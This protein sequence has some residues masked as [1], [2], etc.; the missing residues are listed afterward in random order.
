MDEAGRGTRSLV[1]HIVRG[2]VDDPSAVEVTQAEDERGAVIRVRVGAADI[3][4]VIGRGGR[5]AKAIRTLA[6][7]AAA[8]G[9]G[10]VFIE[11]AE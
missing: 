4:K 2:I 3:G 11:I 10:R 9:G 8:R 7:A 5:V 1:E 6:Q